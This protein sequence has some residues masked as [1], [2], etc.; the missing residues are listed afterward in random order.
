MDRRPEFRGD[1]KRPEPRSEAILLWAL[2][3]VAAGTV[4]WLL[5]KIRVWEIL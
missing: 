2:L 5:V 3:L 4:A 1:P